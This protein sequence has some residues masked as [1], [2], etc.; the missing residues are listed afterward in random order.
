VMNADGSVATFFVSYARAYKVE[1][2]RGFSTV[3]KTKCSNDGISVVLWQVESRRNRRTFQPR[4]AKKNE[5]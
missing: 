3:L 1:L 5:G 4:R 2:P